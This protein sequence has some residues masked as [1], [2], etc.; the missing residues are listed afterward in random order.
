[1]YL[2]ND[3]FMVLGISKS[4]FAAADFLLSS[5]AKCYV[6]DEFKNDDILTTTQ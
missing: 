6:C 2:E 5:G 3:V 1:M 4:G